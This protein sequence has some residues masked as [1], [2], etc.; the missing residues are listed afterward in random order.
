[1][2]K[3]RM[4]FCSIEANYTTARAIEDSFTCIFHKKDY[5]TGAITMEVLTLQVFEDVFVKKNHPTL[6]PPFR[7]ARFL[8]AEANDVFFVANAQEYESHDDFLAKLPEMNNAFRQ[9]YGYLEQAGVLLLVSGPYPELTDEADEQGRQRMRSEQV[10]TRMQQ[11][12]IRRRDQ[13]F[14]KDTVLVINPLTRAFS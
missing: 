12:L 7:Y 13:K 14:A 1:M 9:D 5:D 8:T 6:I 11:R 10:L 2:A 3:L 4:N